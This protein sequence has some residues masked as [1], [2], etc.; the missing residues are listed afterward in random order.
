MRF[1]LLFILFASSASLAVNACDPSYI[2]LSTEDGPE[3]CCLDLEPYEAFSLYFYAPIT[4]CLDGLTDLSFRIS[5]WQDRPDN[6]GG[7]AL[8]EWYADQVEGDVAT[9]IT[10]RWNE[11]VVLQGSPILGRVDFLPLNSS[12]PGSELI[13]IP[14]MVEIVGVSDCIQDA[15]PTSFYLNTGDS[16]Y[17]E[18]PWQGCDWPGDY[19]DAILW[20]ENIYPPDGSELVGDFNLAFDV[21]SFTCN[22]SSG[23]DF[24]GNIKLDDTLVSEFAGNGLEHF[25]IP[26]NIGDYEI[27]EEFQIEIELISYHYMGTVLGDVTTLDYRLSGTPAQPSESWSTLKI[28]Y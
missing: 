22:S 9:G 23:Y 20:A 28:R 25:S 24:E 27:G 13:L 14:D 8:Y 4:G 10:L 2:G 18:C 12:W 5:N 6:P 11:P 26:V 19:V 15:L 7:L 1:A 17:C 21:W 3:S 16:W